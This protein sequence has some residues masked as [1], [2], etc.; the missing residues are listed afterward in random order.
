MNVSDKTL[1]EKEIIIRLLRL[2]W[3]YRIGTVKALVL[4]LLILAV[5]LAGL[6]LTG[7]GIDYIKHKAS[8]DSSIIK[9]PF[10]IQ[11]PTEWTPL[12]I[13]LIIGLLIAIF[14][15]L[16]TWLSYYYSVIMVTFLQKGL[17]VEIR[18]QVYE[19]LQTLSFRFFDS[20]SS[21]TLINRVTGDVQALRLFIDGVLLQSIILVI[22]LCAYIFY[23]ASINLRLM[24][25]CM[26]TVPLIWFI[27]SFTSKILRPAYSKSR[28]LMDALI[29]SICE[30]VQGIHVVKGFSRE[31]EEI[32]IL[33]KAN[34]KIRDQKQTII[35]TVSAFNPLIEFSS[36][37]SIAVLLGYG[38]WLVAKNELPLG[39]GLVVFLGLL[40]RFAGQVN[41][42]TGIVDNVQ[43]SLAAAGRVFAV[44]TAEPEIKN[45][46]NPIKIKKARGA[47]EFKNVSFSYNQKDFVLKDINL[48][49][50]P[51]RLIGILGT[52]GSGKSTLLSLIPRFYDA[53]QGDILLDGINVKNYDISDLRRQVGIVFQESFLFSNTISSNIAFGRP[54][55]TQEEIEK[56]AKIAAA[57]D[58]IMGMAEGYNTVIGEA[59]IDLSGG[60]KQRLAIA[61][62][63]LADP[64]ILLLDDP[65]A[66][67][68]S[69]TEKEI[70]EGLE[71]AVRGRTTFLVSHRINV[72]KR[73]DLIVVLHNGIIVQRGTHAE[74]MRQK[75]HYVR[76]A[77]IQTEASV[78]RNI[79]EL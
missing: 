56:A 42:I 3:K 8:S 43:H 17:V 35:K 60:Q 33:E 20:Q 27:S 64:P 31:K 23:M 29:L 70:L 4:Q 57:H 9:W 40:Q 65:L 24:L 61:R 58:F 62:A 69:Q 38:G 34:D 53:T 54:E 36:Q 71:S 2:A 25:A 1:S 6:S 44:L 11:P 18:A 12:N 39:S 30:R 21:G 22:S 59:G 10:G 51:G 63:I 50:S 49:V 47:V 78:E 28:E 26:A 14:A 48:C 46:P 41:A 52:T 73:A 19:K 79:G 68:D 32:A 45:P 55:A 37:L 67:V 13:L 72:L 16:K 66:A 7:L 5:S 75:G 77:K 15:V 76:T 74:L